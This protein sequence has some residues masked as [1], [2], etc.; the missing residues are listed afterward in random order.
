MKRSKLCIL[1][2]F[3][4]ILLTIP[5]SA[6][7]QQAITTASNEVKSL[8]EFVIGSIVV[9]LALVV[10]AGFLLIGIIGLAKKR[11]QGEP[12]NEEVTHIVVIVAVILLVSSYYLWG[13]QLLSSSS[14]GG[15]TTSP[16]VTTTTTA[17]PASI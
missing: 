10:L 9:P 4:T 3:L 7:V 6:D 8:A 15:A 2:V 14:G 13:P 16:G 11:R 17:A 1:C 12:Y 5:A